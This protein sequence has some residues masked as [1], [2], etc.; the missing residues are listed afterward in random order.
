MDTLE[1]DISDLLF[2]ILCCNNIDDY[3]NNDTSMFW[4]PNTT[5]NI[6]LELQDFAMFLFGYLQL[7]PVKYN[8]FL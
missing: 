2:D 7:L 3:T 5:H 6:H 1:N 4:F 8:D